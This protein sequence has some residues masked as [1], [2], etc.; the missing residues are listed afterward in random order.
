MKKQTPKNFLKLAH[1]INQHKGAKR[2]V[3][4]LI[5]AAEKSADN[6]AKTIEEIYLPIG[7]VLTLFN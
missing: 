3:K 6:G 5:A 2:T 7:Q 4:L 1:R